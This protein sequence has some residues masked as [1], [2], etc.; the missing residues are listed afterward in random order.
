MKNLV[1]YKVGNAIINFRGFPSMTDGKTKKI[2]IDALR[3]RIDD[4]DNNT[5]TH[6]CWGCGATYK[7][8][9]LLNHPKFK[10]LRPE[11]KSMCLANCH[12]KL[13]IFN[14]LIKGCTYR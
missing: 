9:A 6:S 4:N 11:A 5:A 2:W 8:M 10:K 7:E 12:V 13:C 1:P 14:W 3:P